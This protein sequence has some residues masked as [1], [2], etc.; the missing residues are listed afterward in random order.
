MGCGVIGYTTVIYRWNEAQN[1][2][3]E[4]KGMYM[5]GQTHGIRV[6][7]SKG[8]NKKKRRSFVS[9]S[10]QSCLFFVFLTLIITHIVG[11]KRTLLIKKK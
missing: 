10:I 1:R 9:Q 2:W 6:V 5:C 3:G 7:I 8:G 11:M 4:P